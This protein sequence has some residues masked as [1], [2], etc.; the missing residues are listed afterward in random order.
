M[1]GNGF[2][3]SS[4]IQILILSKNTFTGTPR[5]MILLIVMTFIC[6]LDIKPFSVLDV[7]IIFFQSVICLLVYRVISN[8]DS[9]FLFN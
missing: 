2:T 5:I 4:P 9:Y 7:A 3:Q 6:S 1:E 8:M